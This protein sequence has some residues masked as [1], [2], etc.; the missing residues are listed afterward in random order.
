MRTAAAGEGSEPTL[1]PDVP[2]DDLVEGLRRAWAAVCL[3]ITGTPDLGNWMGTRLDDLV[4]AARMDRGGLLLVLDEVSAAVRDA[5]RT[6]IDDELNRRLLRAVYE[7]LLAVDARHQRV[8]A[9]LTAVETPEPRLTTPAAAW[10]PTPAEAAGDGQVHPAGRD[11]AAAAPPAPADADGGPAPDAAPDEGAR[12]LA[13]HPGNPIPTPSPTGVPS[14]PPSS[15]PPGTTE[16]LAPEVAAECG[17]LLGAGRYEDLAAALTEAS[18][19]IRGRAFVRLA[20]A[21]GDRCQA[22]GARRAAADCFLAAW[23]ADRVDD[24]A[25][26]R[27]AELAMQDGDP[28]LAVSYLERLVAVLH[29]RGDRRGALRVHRK[30]TILAPE[31]QD[32]RD[33]LRDALA[34]AEAAG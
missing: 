17:R 3:R 18:G 16:E 15:I 31:R 34:A 5:G 13:L 14:W 29:W 20:L 19:R 21:S 2:L 10:D 11:D 32:L 25:L 12:I 9:G 1:H 6:D 33:Q 24:V 27:L 26:W 30:M 23:N 28:A 22:A 8:A 7:F 4:G